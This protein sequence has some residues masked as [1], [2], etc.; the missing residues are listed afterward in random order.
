M[1]PAP[2][3]TIAW[4]TVRLHSHGGVSVSGTIGDRYLACNLLEHAKDAVRRNGSES[5]I[6]VPNRDVEVDAPG[7]LRELGD[8][9][10][11]ERGDP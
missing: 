1:R 10:P 3:D 2:D 7:H 6:I 8:M 11:S 4:V 5:A 9:A